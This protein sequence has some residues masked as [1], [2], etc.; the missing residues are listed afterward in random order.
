[1][2]ADDRYHQPCR[3]LLETHP[4]PLVAPVLTITEVSY[5]LGSRL[6]AEAEVRFLGDLAGG[7]F[8]VEP[9]HARDWLRISE[10]V[11]QYRDLPLG[12]VDASVVAAAERLEIETVATLDRRHFGV[13][14]PAHV[15][16]LTL[17]P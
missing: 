16:A 5:L 14:R 15:R 11:W 10:L 17:I 8:T 2:D 1:M 6:G 4:G 13:V 9:V 7:A 3:K 12:T